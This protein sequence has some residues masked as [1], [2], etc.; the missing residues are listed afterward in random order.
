MGG[1]GKNRWTEKD[2]NRI[3]PDKIKVDPSAKKWGATVIVCKYDLCIGIDSG[4]NTG[5]A[6]WDSKNKKFTE[7]ST[8]KIHDAIERIKKLHESG[9]KIFVRV[10][11]ARQR[12]WFGNSGKEKLQGAGSVKRDAVIWE[13]FLTDYGIP[14]EMIAPKDNVTKLDNVQF[15]KMTGYTGRTSE[16]GRD[17]AMMVFGM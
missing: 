14:H 12:T 8:I 3:Q 11:D 16:H 17:G 7:I 9:I 5:F 1:W 4:V 15:K 6:I 2:L 13:D 10:E